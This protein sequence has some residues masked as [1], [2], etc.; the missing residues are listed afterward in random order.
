MAHE[1]TENIVSL[2]KRQDFVLTSLVLKT[3]LK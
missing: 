2:I 1:V 3:W